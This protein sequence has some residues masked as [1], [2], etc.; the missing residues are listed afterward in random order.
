[1]IRPATIADIPF[2]LSVA[3]ACYSHKFD[4]KSVVH[5]LRQA[6][7]S[8]HMLVLRSERGLLVASIVRQFWGGEP[9]AFVQ[10]LAA[11]PSRGL[12]GDG[13]RLVRAADE[14]RRERGADSLRFGEE[15]GIQMSAIARRLGA[16]QDTPS[17]I[18]RGGAARSRASDAA[19]S[20][21]GATLLDR[22]LTYPLLPGEGPALRLVARDG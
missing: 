6:M 7:A 1:M 19:P 9:E 2:L 11:I 10:F 14:W 16:V 8:P 4:E 3:R 17:F 18:I 13:L 22:V 20:G 15:T 12:I 21:L 5:F